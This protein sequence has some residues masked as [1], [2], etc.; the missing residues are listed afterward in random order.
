M[1][2]LRIY[3]VNKENKLNEKVSK[4]LTDIIYMCV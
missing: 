1:P 2:L 4:R 3:N